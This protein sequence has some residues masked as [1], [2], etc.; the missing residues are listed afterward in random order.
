[1]V[2]S[3]PGPAASGHSN[4]SAPDREGGI[5][6]LSRLM[7]EGWTM[8]A[9]T[10]PREWCNMPLAKSRDGRVMCC[11][12][13]A[14]VVDSPPAASGSASTSA[15]AGPSGTAGSAAA[16]SASTVGGDETPP[17]PAD[18]ATPPA[19]GGVVAVHGSRQTVSA[20][21][22][23]KLLQG[24]TMLEQAC[25][26][27]GTPLL[28]SASGTVMCVQCASVGA[29]GA[30][31]PRPASSL[32]GPPAR[33][34]LPAPPPVSVGRRAVPLARALPAPGPSRTEAG[35]GAGVRTS[36]PVDVGVDA[37]TYNE[38]GLAEQAAVA[39]MRALR[40]SLGGRRDVEG[41]ASVLRG[42]REAADTITAVRRARGF[43]V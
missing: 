14:D 8:L 15:G 41:I 22:G 19:A 18:P 16:A 38:L 43:S 12:C 10:C 24:W 23:E 9:E 5:E 35:A 7:L 28:R 32:P 37:D 31:A 4:G 11:A 17:P 2:R 42:M 34:Q 36:V 25:A 30:G 21:L 13:N 3:P 27:C 39:A 40:E 6:Q 1:M 20:A 33:P 29:A 26:T